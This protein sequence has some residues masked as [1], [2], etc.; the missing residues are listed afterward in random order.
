MYG[1]IKR[2]LKGDRNK[3]IMN[4]TMAF[5]MFLVIV[6]V[7]LLNFVNYWQTLMG[8]KENISLFPFVVGLTGFLLF[9]L[10]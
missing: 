2:K 9:M 10:T 4:N 3:I 1:I 7:W 5:G 8:N 6:S